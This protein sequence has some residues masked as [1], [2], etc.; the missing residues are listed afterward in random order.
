MSDPRRVLAATRAIRGFVDGGVSVVLANHLSRLS[1]S[2]PQ[3]GAVVTGTMVGSAFVILLMGWFGHR[4]PRR[5]VLFFCTALMA[6]TG[7]GF[8]AFD[9]FWPLL[10][11]ALLGTL[12]PGAGDVSLFLPTEQAALAELSATNRLA[13]GYAWFNLA[14]SLA[15]A[16]G[17]G[18]V[19]LLVRGGVDE[20]EL[21][22]VVFIAYAAAGG[23]QALLY[24]R[25]PRAAPVA[26]DLPRTVLA[27]SRRDV[28]TLT[29]LFSLDSFGGGLVVQALLA[30]WLQRR[31]SLGL[32]ATAAY[33]F[34]ANLLAALSQ[35]LSA[36]LSDRIGHVRTMVVT[37]LPASLMLIAAGLMPS[38][39]LAVGVL[40]VR[41]CLTQMDVP[42]RQAFTMALVPKE[43]RAA[44]ANVTNLPR[45]L[46][47][48]LAPLLTGWLLTLEDLRWPLLL[49]GAAKGLYDVLLWVRFRKVA[50]PAES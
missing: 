47:A 49:G 23:V 42:A 7:L 44:A 3:M 12:N 41:A 14:G 31:F 1:F 13:H 35:P 25:L 40:L 28:L 5:T 15:I 46:A 27:K 8:L 32:D 30:H 36:R 21:T 19:S 43:E 11:V 18:G 48:G 39:P 16:L 17:A 38:A 24:R 26:R 37:H 34:A 20:R 29:A 2:E 45:S 50:P 33:F 6:A 10:L 22:R 9:S 4:L